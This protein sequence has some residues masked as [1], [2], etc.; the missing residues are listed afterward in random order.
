MK[1]VIIRSGGNPLSN[2]ISLTYSEKDEVTHWKHKHTHPGILWQ[3][4]MWT[5]VTQLGACYAWKRLCQCI[6]VHTVHVQTTLHVCV[7][8][9]VCVCV[10]DD[11]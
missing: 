3:Q 4:L 8:V 10:Y 2:Y 7:C 6:R 9:C 11:W 1:N 5:G